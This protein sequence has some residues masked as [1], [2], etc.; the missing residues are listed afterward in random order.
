MNRD[1]L[2]A[3]WKYRDL[4]FNSGEAGKNRQGKCA[5]D[6]NQCAQQKIGYADLRFSVLVFS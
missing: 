6:E 5:D 4:Q 3:I 1:T 2:P